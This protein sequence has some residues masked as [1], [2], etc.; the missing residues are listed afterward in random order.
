MAEESEGDE[1]IEDSDEEAM[2]M[3]KSKSYLDDQID[4]E[5]GED[6]DESGEASSQESGEQS[7]VEMES[8][9]D[10]KPKLK[11]KKALRM[12]IDQEKQIRLKE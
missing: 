7:D 11:G 3:I 8:E 5:S 4:E 2:N 12:Q 9:S 10:G 1:E 6:D